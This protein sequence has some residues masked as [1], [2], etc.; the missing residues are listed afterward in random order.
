MKKF[1]SLL[2]IFTL[3][4]TLPLKAFAS[5]NDLRAEETDPNAKTYTLIPPEKVFY[6]AGEAP[7]YTGAKVIYG[8]SIFSMEYILT[9]ANCRGFDTAEPGN[10]TVT[11]FLNEETFYFNIYVMR[12]DDPIAS[13]TDISA[14]HWAYQYLGPCMRMGYF[15]GYGDGTVKAGQPITRAQMAALIWRAWKNDPRVMIGNHPEAVESFPDADPEGWY[16]EAME[17]CRKAGI[18]RGDENGNCNPADPILRQDALLMLMRIQYT[19]EELAEADPEQLIEAS[20]L[21]PTDFEQVSAY[22]KNAVALALG[23]M[24]KGDE[25]GAIN[26]KKTISRGESAA[27]FARLFLSDYDWGYDWI[28]DDPAE[29]AMPLVYLSPSNQFYNSYAWGNTT[30]GAEMTKVAEAAKDLLKAKGYR[31]V[32]AARETSI[33]DRPDEAIALGADVYVPIHSNAG[34]NKVGTTVF[35]RGD[36]D[37]SYQL[38]DYLFEELAEITHTPR[39]DENTFVEDYENFTGS[40]PYHELEEPTMA[41][42]Y[43]EVEYHDKPE[44][45]KWIIENTDPLALAICDGVS[46]YCENHLS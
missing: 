33:Y 43:L 22:A 36:R 30:E 6:T 15:E 40:S 20:G 46:Q 9:A 14:H 44:K 18:L 26:P 10:K 37:S 8:N 28:Q 23:K 24:I 19:D 27:I 35:Y 32:V 17:A 1:L 16:F 45:A 31:V 11:V 12:A 29:E 41:V 7:D 3:L 25:N 39:I 13:M 34:A 21:D 42:A 4:L 5:P 38:A 2:L